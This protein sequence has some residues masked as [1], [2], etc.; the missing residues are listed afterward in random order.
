MKQERAA[1]TKSTPKATARRRPTARPPA[2][3]PSVPAPP[4]VRLDVPAENLVPGAPPPRGEWVNRVDAT[5]VDL[6]G[7]VAIDNTGAAEA[8]GLPWM[9]EL[10][11]HADEAKRHLEPIVQRKVGTMWEPGADPFEDEPCAYDI[12]LGDQFRFSED[13]C[14][15]TSLFGPGGLRQPPPRLPHADPNATD[16]PGDA[17]NLGAP[18]AIPAIET[19]NGLASQAT[20]RAAMAARGEVESGATLW[21]M[22]TTGRSAAGEAQFWA[23]E[24]PLTPGFAARHGVPA[25]NVLNAD[26]IESAVL[27][28]GSPFITRGAPGVGSN[29]GGAIEV[30]VPEGGIWL[31]G[32][33]WF[34]PKGAQ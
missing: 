11:E 27:R 1:R 28:P 33:S 23:L 24:H 20:S 12:Y 22:G 26:F 19:P 8:V 18:R 2:R 29:L 4:V 21:R 30:V 9:P 16:D 13:N 3:P 14:N 15:G 25:R 5:T 7:L 32:F 6:D 34:G 10:S 31:R 17:I